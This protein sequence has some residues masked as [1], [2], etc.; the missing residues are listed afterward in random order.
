MNCWAGIFLDMIEDS[1]MIQELSDYE[2]SMA[3]QPLW[4][5]AMHAGESTPGTRRD[6]FAA[7]LRVIIDWMVPED[8]KMILSQ[9]SQSSEYFRWLERKR[10][11]EMLLAEADRAE[12]IDEYYLGHSDAI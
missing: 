3:D 9:T 10:L 1:A 4:S 12:E 5:L 2:Q 7:E 6:A 8:D 11:R